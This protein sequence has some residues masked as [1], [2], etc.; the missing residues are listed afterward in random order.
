MLWRR[1][2]WLVPLAKTPFVYRMRLVRF[3][4]TACV[5]VFVVDASSASSF[6]MGYDVQGDMLG[7]RCADIMQA[8]MSFS[9]MFA[10]AKDIRE[11]Y[12]S[13]YSSGVPRILER[14]MPTCAEVARVFSGVA[15]LRGET[16]HSLS[17][18][19]GVSESRIIEAMTSGK[20]STPDIMALC[21]VL[22]IKPV[23]LPSVSELSGE[24][25]E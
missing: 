1:A 22:G 15:D 8:A 24:S 20:V 12:A 14:C 7:G 21:R 4:R 18:A 17:D 6:K 2:A 25:N 19:S 5:F 16:A 13:E 11:L 3:G 23:M 10:G 9:E